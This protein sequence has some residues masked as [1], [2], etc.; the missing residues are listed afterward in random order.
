MSPG[1]VSPTPRSTLRRKRERGSHER[2]TIDAVLDE[3]LVCHVGLLDGGSVFVVPTAYARVGDDVLLHGAVA[4]RTLRALADGAEACVTVTLVDGLVLSRSAF[5]HSM[6]YRSVMLFGTAEK[7]TDEDDKRAAV[8]A[9]V[10][11]LVPGR[12]GDT[13]PPTPEELRSTLVLRFPIRDGSAKVRQ[14][15]PIEEA[16]DLALGHW[17]GVLPLTLQPGV[18]VPDEHLAAVAERAEGAGVAAPAYLVDYHRPHRSDAPER[19]AL[20]EAW[21]A[22]A[23]AWIAW[24]RTP[25]HDSYWRFHRD[26]FCPSCPRPHPRPKGS[27]STWVVAKAGCRA[28]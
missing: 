15:D 9:I 21:E 25:G 23:P 26:A 16:E 1:A 28:T 12:S 19:R 20:R 6:N 5:H 24:A 7:V 10:E 18:P 13:R 4:N 11:H 2:A 17:A 3:G 22:A 14:G 27:P 8:F